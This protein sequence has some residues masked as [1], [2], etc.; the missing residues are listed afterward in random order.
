MNK[1]NDIL[2]Y[3]GGESFLDQHLKIGEFYSIKSFGVVD[4]NKFVTF[5]GT[6]CACYYK[7]IK[8]YF[9]NISEERDIK[10]TILLK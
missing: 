6:N 9:Q 8:K 10:L 7:D 1:E 5:N 4:N 2:K 3:L